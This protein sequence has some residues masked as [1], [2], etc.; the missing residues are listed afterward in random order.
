ME[1]VGPYVHEVIYKDENVILFRDEKYITT[2]SKDVTL[3]RVF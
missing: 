1:F 3:E 2:K